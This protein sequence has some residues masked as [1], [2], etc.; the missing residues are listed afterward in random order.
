MKRIITI[1]TSNSEFD[2]AEKV[3]RA[4]KDMGVEQYPKK[5]KNI[6]IEVVEEVE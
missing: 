3:K 4:L 1:L 5:E 2:I 6:I